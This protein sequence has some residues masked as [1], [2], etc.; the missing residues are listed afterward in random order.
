MWKGL[1]LL[2]TTEIS[3]VIKRNVAAFAYYGVAVVAAL[4]ALVY[5]VEAAHFWLT[6]RM[7]PLAASLVIAAVFLAIAVLLM[8][9]GMMVRNAKPKPSAR[10]SLTASALVAAPVAARLFGKRLQLGTVA[11]AGVVAVGAALGRYLGTRS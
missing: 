9:I 8:L 1:S 3:S 11:V 5:L 2:A 4:F 10:S 6:L 7:S